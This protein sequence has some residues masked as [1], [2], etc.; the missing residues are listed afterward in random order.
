MKLAYEA[1]IFDLDGIITQTAA[2]H[3]KAWKKVFDEFLESSSKT[4]DRSYS[5]FTQEDYLKYV[6]GKPR[7]EGVMTFLESRN[8]KLP[9]GNEADGFSDHTIFGV[10]NQKNEYFLEILKQEGA[11]VYESTRLLLFELKEA[12][13]K[14]GVASSSKNCKTVLESVGLLPMFEAL[15]DG[16]VTAE[17]NLNGKPAPDIF[18][19]ACEFM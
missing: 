15:V 3:F 12:E 10:G 18:I 2:I 7:Y 19:K 17:L 9:Q 6:D 4:N 8:I 14:Q 1:V 13:V 16:L 5:E 11:E